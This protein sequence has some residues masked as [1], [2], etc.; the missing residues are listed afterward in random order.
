VDGRGS[1]KSRIVSYSTMQM[2]A[3]GYSV[4]HAAM[5]P[6]TIVSFSCAVSNVPFLQLLC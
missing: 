5:S 4:C 6:E 2:Q 3:T 1:G